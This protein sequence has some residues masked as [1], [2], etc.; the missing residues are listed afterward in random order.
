MR[1]I[2][3]YYSH[4]INIEPNREFKEYQSII[5]RY[6]GAILNP[7]KEIATPNQFEMN[8]YWRVIEKV[9]YIIVSAINGKIGRCSYYE[10][11]QGLTQGVT[12]QEIYSVGRGF[13]YIKVIGLEIATEKNLNKY[14]KLI[15]VPLKN[16][17]SLKHN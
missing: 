16:R 9:N 17:T 2:L 8:V 12:V 13:K 4:Q 7:T 11:K 6:K 5:N 10:V 15:C 14:A 1:Q 3:G